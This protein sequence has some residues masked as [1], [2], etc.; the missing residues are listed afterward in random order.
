MRQ[1]VTVPVV[2]TDSNTNLLNG[3]P[4]AKMPGR[5]VLY[6]WAVSTQ[7]DGTL[8][9]VSNQ[10][11]KPLCNGAV[12]QSVSAINVFDKRAVVPHFAD[13]EK[14]EVWTPNYTE[15]TAATAQFIFQWVGE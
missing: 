1:S 5:G 12:I 13:V 3:T 11:R 2:T 7:A 8:T 4:L 6:V 9:M 14:D 15:V 10:N